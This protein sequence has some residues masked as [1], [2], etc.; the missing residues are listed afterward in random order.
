MND[1]INDFT[2]FTHRPR[3]YITDQHFSP[4]HTK[5][6]WDKVWEAARKEPWYNDRDIS[7]VGNKDGYFY[8]QKRGIVTGFARIYIG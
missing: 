7:C 8:F 3:G 5:P 6:L 4:V 2:H 1:L